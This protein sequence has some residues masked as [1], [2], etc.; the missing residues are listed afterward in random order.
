MQNL[1]NYNDQFRQAIS[2]QQ[3]SLQ[4]TTSQRKL[5]ITDSTI[6]NS[7]DIE[8]QNLFYQKSKNKQKDNNQRS[9][10]DYRKRDDYRS[11]NYQSNYQ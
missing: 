6:D 4:N 1:N 2:M 11:Q 9:R 3:V 5:I 10:N 8:N 7:I